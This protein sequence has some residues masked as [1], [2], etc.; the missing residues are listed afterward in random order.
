MSITISHSNVRSLVA[1]FADFRDYITELDY[2]VAGV[3]ETWLHPGIDDATV[4]VEGF[5]FIHQDRINRRGGGVGLY[6]KNSIQFNVVNFGCLDFVEYMWVKLLINSKN[7]L[8]GILYRPPGTNLDSFFQ[9]F[10]DILSDL[11]TSYDNIVC[12][13]DFNINLLD[14]NNKTKKL[15][16][17]ADIFSMKQ[18]IQQPTRVNEGSYSLIDLIFCNMP[19][20]LSSGV[21]DTHFF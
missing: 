15:E 13:G 6:I 7:I 14:L 21:A 12:L 11:Y 18:Y 17:I 3:T 8:L 9:Y 19:N 1:N 10:E 5:N 2:H 4:S 16:D 20:V